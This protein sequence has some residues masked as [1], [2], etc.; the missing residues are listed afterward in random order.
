MLIR[1]KGQEY[2]YKLYFRARVDKQAEYRC[3]VSSEG[4]DQGCSASKT[5]NSSASDRIKIL[6]ENIDKFG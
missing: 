2:E 1:T 5:L 3:W 4:I 6:Q